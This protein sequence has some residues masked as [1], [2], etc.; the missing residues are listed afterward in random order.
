[1]AYMIIEVIVNNYNYETTGM[2]KI[3]PEKYGWT[4]ARWWNYVIEKRYIQDSSLVLQLKKQYIQV[5]ENEGSSI[6]Q[7]NKR[8]VEYIIDRSHSAIDSKYIWQ[9]WKQN[10][11]DIFEVMISIELGEFYDPGERLP[12]WNYIKEKIK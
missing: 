4:V 5:M 8:I 1:M 12:D 7:M 9:Y 3:L 6:H 11:S 10:V 2:F